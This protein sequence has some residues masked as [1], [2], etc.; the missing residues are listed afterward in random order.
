MEKFFPNRA[1]RLSK[2]DYLQIVDHIEHCP[3]CSSPHEEFASSLAQL[4]ASEHQ[5]I[6]DDL[7]RHIEQ[8]NLQERFVERA[9]SAGIQFSETFAK[10]DQSKDRVLV[11]HRWVEAAALLAVL[12]VVVGQHFAPRV[13]RPTPRPRVQAFEQTAVPSPDQKSHELE[14]KL[15]GLQAARN[16][17]ARELSAMRDENAKTALELA[18]LA[19][20]LTGKRAE[21]QS[22]R[23]SI[24]R[25]HELEIR[26]TAEIA[27]NTQMLARA[28]AELDDARTREKTLEAEAGAQKAEVATLTQQLSSKTTTIA[29]ERELLAAGRDIT[30]LMGARN[31][32]IIDVRDADG[33]GKNKK[34]FGR[35]FYTEGK[36]L[37]FYAYDLNEGKA[38]K[39]DYSFEVW[40]ERLGEPTSI[41]S[42]GILY[43]DKKEQERWALTVDDPQQLA[44]ID[45]IFVTLEPHKGVSRPRGGQILFA[46][47]GGK[48]NHP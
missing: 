21:N 1:N 37:I 8:G 16:A 24:Q 48:A 38:E 30:D 29:H 45:S 36:S 23:E 19:K 40:G 20:D 27:T 2:N 15:A 28:Q 43:T 42:L 32:H 12:V 34:S 39:T 7:L 25:L 18:G 47:L 4:P 44:E 22:L 41:R 31:L 26:Q 3:S 35:I 14:A 10:R 46:F 9:R 11:S 17:A 5:R 33:K 6:K 13:S